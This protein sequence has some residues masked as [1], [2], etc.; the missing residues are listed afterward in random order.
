MSNTNESKSSAGSQ[1]I[2]CR[3]Y[4]LFRLNTSLMKLRAA[5]RESDADRLL[6][7]CAV[8]TAGWMRTSKLGPYS[9]LESGQPDSVNQGDYGE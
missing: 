4:R 5:V 3:L 2:G 1:L 8:P 6:A 7:T 9:L